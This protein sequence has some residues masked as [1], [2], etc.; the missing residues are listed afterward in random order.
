MAR[1]GT[2]TRW[3]LSDMLASRRDGRKPRFLSSLQSGQESPCNPCPSD[4]SLGR[5]L[6][7]G[8]A[9]NH[10]VSRC[11]PIGGDSTRPPDRR[12]KRTAPYPAIDFSTRPTYV[13]NNVLGLTFDDGPDSTN[14]ALV[15][16]VL[17]SKG[18]KATFFINTTT[19]GRQY[20]P[21]LKADVQRIVA[22]VTCSAATRCTT[23][24]C[25]R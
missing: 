5:P 4:V 19:T 1:R 6:R 9:F 20:D 25:P 10:W 11:Q 16:D 15:L 2:V 18:V 14:T 21:A 8:R 23:C 13:A 22:E 12:S 7:L 3:A 17:K 24:I